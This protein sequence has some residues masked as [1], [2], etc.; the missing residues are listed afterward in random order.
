VN[1]GHLQLTTLGDWRSLENNCPASLP[2][3]PVTGGLAFLSTVM[4]N[5]KRQPPSTE[6]QARQAWPHLL[7]SQGTGSLRTPSKWITDLRFP[8]HRLRGSIGG[9]TCSPRWSKPPSA[10]STPCTE[11][12]LHRGSLSLNLDPWP[13][14]PRP[15]KARPGSTS[16][17]S[18]GPRVRPANRDSASSLHAQTGWGEIGRGAEPRDTRVL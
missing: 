17:A 10:S 4:F 14:A 6:H 16:P 18:S 5:S 15:I 8:P 11:V 12:E 13:R 9:L 1:C 7:E 2:G 3:W